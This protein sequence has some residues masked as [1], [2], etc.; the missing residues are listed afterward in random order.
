MNRIGWVALGAGTLAAALWGASLDEARAIGGGGTPDDWIAQAMAPAEELTTWYAAL[1]EGVIL[2]VDATVPVIT[3]NTRTQ[4][5]HF[6]GSDLWLQAIGPVPLTGSSVSPALQLP[7]EYG[8][9][10]GELWTEIRSGFPNTT[11]VVESPSSIDPDFVPNP[12]QD[13]VWYRV[14][15][16]FG[17]ASNVAVYVALW[18]DTQSYHLA[19]VRVLDAVTGEPLV[20][21]REPLGHGAHAREDRVSTDMIAISLHENDHTRI[22]VPLGPDAYSQS[23]DT[24]GLGY[25]L[26]LDGAMAYH[27]AIRRVDLAYDEALSTGQTTGGT[28]LAGLIAGPTTCAPGEELVASG[29]LYWRVPE[30]PATQQRV[31]DALATCPVELEMTPRV[32]VAAA[33][34][35]EACVQGTWDFVNLGTSPPTVLW[36]ELVDSCHTGAIREAPTHT[37]SMTVAQNV[38]PAHIG[39]RFTGEARVTCTN[40]AVELSEATFDGRGDYGPHLEWDCWPDWSL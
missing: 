39:V 37:K 27:D 10:L 21:W 34:D 13:E 28:P 18:G 23:H 35:V 9:R 33:S 22:D 2:R 4:R 20:S 17:W 7:D 19:F 29:A 11:F 1:G 25:G 30:E 14:E 5:I 31:L 6:D 12:F 38:D 8:T 15:L 40:S 26:A 3:L 16:P 36:T 24:N 32:L